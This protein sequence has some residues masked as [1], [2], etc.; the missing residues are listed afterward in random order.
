[1][2]FLFYCNL[3]LYLLFLCIW[4][5]NFTCYYRTNMCCLH[6]NMNTPCCLY[7]MFN[8]SSSHSNNMK[9]SKDQTHYSTLQGVCVVNFQKFCYLPKD[10]YFFAVHDLSYCYTFKDWYLRLAVMI[11]TP[12]PRKV[13]RSENKYRWLQCTCSV[14]QSYYGVQKVFQYWWNYV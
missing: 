9:I 2:V 5:T 8:T 4:R 14:R 13:F 3:L 12:N 1:M 10:L 11:L 6:I 7:V